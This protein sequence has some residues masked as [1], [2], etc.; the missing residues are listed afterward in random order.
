[1]KAAVTPGVERIVFDMSDLLSIEPEGVTALANA[2]Q[3]FR[4]GGKQ[5][6]I[7]G[8][9]R[10][11][12]AIAY[13]NEAGF[14]RHYLGHDAPSH[15]SVDVNTIPLHLFKAKEYV[16]YLYR[17]LMPWLAD[18]LRVQGDTLETIKAVLEEVF[19]N[20]DFHASIDTGCVFAEHFPKKNRVCIAISDWGVGIAHN[21]RKA[22][23]VAHDAAALELATQEG[24]TTGHA[25][26]NRGAGLPNLLKYVAQRNAGEV[27]IFSGYGSLTATRGTAQPTIHSEPLKWCY[28]GTIVHVVLRTDT[29]DRFQSD[30]QPEEF[31]W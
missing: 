27:R 19:H 5:V 20:V 4:H 12:K 22:Q 18:E 31:R 24:F 29:L 1:M 8:H 10:Y 21:V 17:R 11:S 26:R 28:P 15:A 2:I 6:F 23:T 9:N 25:P 14:M 16:P 30:V 3:H 7:R 13:L